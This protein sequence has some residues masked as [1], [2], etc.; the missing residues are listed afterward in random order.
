MPTASANGSRRSLAEAVTDYLD[1]IKLSKKPKTLSAY[2]TA[3]TYFQESCKKTHLE[4][5]DRKDMIRFKAYL[6]D[7]KEQSPR[8]CWNKFSNVMGFLKT[9]DV[10]KLVKPGDWPT[11]VDE[12]PEIYEPEELEKFLS[13]CTVQERI[14]FEFFLMTGMREPR[15]SGQ[16]YSLRMTVERPIA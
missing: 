7:E 2:T 5:I 4:D 16:N 10:R 9:Y 8:S 13:V 14:W 1:E 11:Y 15:I 6:R 3:L 12:E